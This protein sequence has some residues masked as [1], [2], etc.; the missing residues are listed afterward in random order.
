MLQV[1]RLAPTLL[2]DSTDLVADFLRGQMHPEGGFCNRAGENDLYYTVFGLQSLLALQIELPI[3]SLKPYLERF[4]RPAELDLVH[5]AALARCWA[6]AEPSLSETR[7]QALAARL[8]HFR[9]ADGGYHLQTGRKKGSAYACFLALG[10]YQ[11]LNLQLPNGDIF[12]ACVQ[13]MGESQVETRSTPELAAVATLK[14]YL[15]KPL[16]PQLSQSLLAR[17]HPQ[18]GFS[19][20]A[21][22]PI[23][24]LLSTAVAL[25]ALSGL[26]VDLDGLREPCLDFVDSLW[27]NRGSFYGHWKD[28]A[29][30]A[31][32]TFY[33]LLALG[34]LSV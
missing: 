7:S 26:Q 1:A 31:E 15:G 14:R 9:A 19:A 32:Y 2:R 4:E 28:D 20:A 33:G 21:G 6:T 25:H 3:A 8:E 29:L 18:G 24:D 11:D 17:V 22:T 34:H 16:P 12:L 27:T 30:D 5:L 13:A 23:P 10:A